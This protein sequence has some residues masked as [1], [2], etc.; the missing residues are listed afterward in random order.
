MNTYEIG[1]VRTFEIG[2][3]TRD[4]CGAITYMVAVLISVSKESGNYVGHWCA[5]V[6]LLQRCIIG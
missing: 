6:T 4:D 2:F 5:G 1:H 3:T